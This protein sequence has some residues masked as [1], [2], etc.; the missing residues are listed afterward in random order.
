MSRS[1]SPVAEQPQDPT[2]YELDP[3]LDPDKRVRKLTEKAMENYEAK[4]LEFQNKI[5]I[6]LDKL[7]EF[8]TSH[9]EISET[10]CNTIEK[11]R[12]IEKQLDILNKHYRAI[13]MEFI[14]FLL[15][16]GTEESVKESQVYSLQSDQYRVVVNDFIDRLKAIVKEISHESISVVSAL[17]KLSKLSNMITIKQAQLEAARV[18]AE[19]A[20]R[21]AVLRKERALL[22]EK[23]KVADAARTRM[24]ANLE[25]DIELLNKQ[26]EF[27]I[28][29]AETNALESRS[30]PSIKIDFLPQE[31]PMDRVENFVNKQYELH[32]TTCLKQEPISD[33]YFEKPTII[34]DM[35]PPVT[36]ECKPN[37]T[38]EPKQLPEANTC[39]IDNINIGNDLTK[40]L[41]R[42]DLSLS[43]LS[44]FN[45]RPE[46]YHTWK[47]SFCDVMREM[48]VGP[49][50][51]MDLL[52]KW[53]GSD[54]KKH[55]LSLR[56]SNAHNPANGLKK[57]WERLDERFGS[58]EM[59][60]TAILKKLNDFPKLGLK[61]YAKLYELS[62][63][64]GEIE[65]LKE[66]PKY[67]T[68]LAYFDSSVGVSPIVNKL[69]Y[70]IQ[71][72][73]TTRANV[74]KK[75][76][77]VTFP[78]F[79]VFTEFISEQ[80][81][82]KNDPSFMYNN[83]QF[84]TEKPA[85]NRRPVIATKITDIDK[86]IKEPVTAKYTPEASEFPR[87][88]IHK[89]KHSLNDCRTFKSKSL[90]ERKAFLKNNNLCFR[91]CMSTAHIA[92]NCDKWIKCNDCGSSRHA[93]AMH[94]QKGASN[95]T[96]SLHGGEE[97]SKKSVTSKCTQVCGKI[98]RGGKSCAKLVLVKVYQANKPECAIKT[99]AILD[100]QSNRSLAR[101]ELF[102]KLNIDSE[103]FEY[104]LNTCSDTVVKSGRRAQD[105]IVEH[106]DGS[107]SYQLPTL[108]E[109]SQIPNIR[110]EIPTSE[111]AMYHSH[112]QD[113]APCIPDI[114][115]EADI[116]L[117]IGRDLIDVHYVL[118]QK[119]G[120][121]GSPYAQRLGLGW[122]VI[123]EV[124]LGKVHRPESV[125]VNK[126]YLVGKERTSVC[127]PCPNKIRIKET[128][129]VHSRD[130]DLFVRTAQDEKIGPSA[131]D[132]EFLNLME[133]EFHKDE[134]GNWSAP[135]P[136][137]SPRP[138]LPNNK[139][140]AF[141]RARILDNSL[142]KNPLKKSHFVSFMKD[143]FDNGHAERAPPLEES[144]EC[145]Y[146][147]LFGVYHPKKP[148]QIRGVFDASAKHQGV[149]LN[150]VL[151]SGPD[152]TNSLLGVLLRFR[153][154]PIAVSADI[155][156]MFYCFLVDEKH[157]NLLR[158]LWYADNDP[159]KEL[160]EYRMKV[161]VFGN[162]PSPAVATYG[163]QRTADISEDEF[164]ADVKEFV[165][166]D[167]YVD[168]G[169][170]SCPTV[171]RAVDLMKR[172][173]Q[174][175]DVNGNLRLHK[176]ASNS[177][178]VMGAFPSEDLAKD[179]A[180]LDLSEA[181]LPLQRSLGLSWNLGTDTF[182]FL[183][184]EEK[185]AYTRRGILSTVNSI[186]D[187]IGFVAPVV[188]TGKL[189]LRELVTGTQD[190]DSPLPEHRRQEWESWRDSLILLEKLQIPRS[191]FS[192]PMSEMTRRELLVFSDASE[193][194]IAAA[195]YFIGHASEGTQYKSLV[196]GKAKVA[197]KNGHTIP[198]LELCAAV[199]AVEIFE[200]ISENLRIN[201]DE[202]FF[203]TDSKVVLGYIQNRTRRFYT[204][205]SNRVEKI[206]RLSSPDQWFYVNTKD[207]PADCA[208]RPAQVAN[209]LNS[210]WLHGPVEVQSESQK[211]LTNEFPL[212][213]PD[214]DKEIRPE[215]HTLDTNV[216]TRTLGSL[217]FERFSSWTHLVGA[218][219]NLLHISQSYSHKKKC[220]GW[221]ICPD[222]KSVLNKVKAEQLI[223][224]TVQEE[225]FQEE[226]FS[227][228]QSKEIPR[229]SSLL[230]LSPVLD[231]HGIL[232]VGGRL[233]HASVPSGEKHPV[234]I[235]RNSHLA[236]LII[237]HY[238]EQVKHQGR[239]LT[240]GAVRSAGFWIIGCKRLISSIL[241][242]CVM[243][244][245]LRREVNVQKMS[246]LPADRVQPT[247]PF[248]YV[249]VDTFGPWEVLA[250]RTRGGQANSKRWAL[251]F[252]CLTARAVHIEVIESL[253][254]SAFINAFRRFTA[255]RGEV[256][257]IRS[258]QGTNFIGATDDLGIDSV[259][260]QDD[261][262]KTFLHNKG[263]TWI[264][265]PPHSSHMGGVWERMIGVARR[266]LD[267]MLSDIT[268]KH[269]THEV[270]TTL[271][272]EVSA[273]IN[274]RPLVPVSSDH[275]CPEILSPAMLLTQK[276]SNPVHYSY[277]PV[278]PRIQWK[279]VQ[280]LA[281]T[282]WK[283]WRVEYLQTLQKRRKWQTDVQ[284]LKQGDVVLLKD[285]EVHRNDWPLGLIVS[286][287]PSEDTRVRK[288][289]VRVVRG[290]KCS[291]YTRPISE[292]VLLVPEE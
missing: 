195:A 22:E 118:E 235:P 27:A 159:E 100:E 42:K 125:N 35:K 67:A 217:R 177:K 49:S 39:T 237:R 137:R 56:A 140:Q 182:T 117:L 268:T 46:A 116:L 103:E 14:S 58:P 247:P 119:I 98:H 85:L 218:V 109:C 66:D 107:V 199:L 274:A 19:Y 287:F 200:S 232:R 192:L 9:A 16:T 213:Q 73:W 132:K 153:R 251:L 151:L 289:E 214:E 136:F 111:V 158:F 148:N 272:A 138:K 279:Y 276:V 115:E 4:K 156:K 81:K 189:F 36:Q 30:E 162:S 209:M 47:S 26:K 176:I 243:C 231:S 211:N 198:R 283:R 86:E 163:L 185:K 152:L 121:P 55:A 141:H 183:V 254:S 292:L 126:T 41:L 61:D 205:V 25:T 113:I 275:D 167:F 285:K 131:E 45:D 288:A 206:C 181:D 68:M 202:V 252:T 228:Q 65:S 23:E 79:W 257:E 259:K 57:I 75:T 20:E 246:D 32:N 53:L 2:D 170:T 59:I 253:S 236:V 48:G 104:T 31:D 262:T 8:L 17:S 5:Q 172:T 144:E 11:A 44:N 208:T 249:G 29:A 263:T 161:H 241:H 71:E 233:K 175:L 3:Q 234:I 72:K 154:E 264:F 130:H 54:S 33:P 21:E 245:K 166:K 37:V 87:C 248:T 220:K 90:E 112:L 187:P 273:I 260:V 64:L 277:Q 123:G 94:I 222:S 226:V 92:R 179:L 284:N 224:R 150:D 225:M 76:H 133:K 160:I 69:T 108:I 291:I 28:F 261:P 105:C 227:L 255:I 157:R 165:A 84:H 155:Q 201:F 96:Q 258:D 106:L 267:S 230:N 149:S 15:R 80:A 188:V 127:Q 281:D 203:Y 190:W 89:T 18:R 99:Y 191:Y 91:C 171:D 78:S 269:L 95:E 184:S 196:L 101:P 278:D 40:F 114:D 256:K 50:E 168:D 250:R 238:H 216:N 77:S 223:I 38:Y 186:Y 74:F 270:L 97:T 173:Q 128:S 207:N 193:K 102:S 122:V 88:P 221:H 147:P 145:W 7:S 82:V 10:T 282:F 139:Q 210:A 215:I 34:N 110:D 142:K 51:E 180:Y 134:S 146:L 174:A 265:N 12:D 52:V 60:Y 70:N 229:K 194:A 143:I 219:E 6:A 83:S 266:I 240:E 204:Y 164:G 212:I 197:P 24:K 244:R 120:P 62:D 1:N 135:L 271:M 178:K 169:L 290:D 93:T 129:L 242:R 124:C 43:R 13:C 286:V 239:H 63:I 280:A